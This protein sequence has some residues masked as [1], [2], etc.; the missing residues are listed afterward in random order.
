MT[1]TDLVATEVRPDGA[2]WYVVQ[3]KPRS[4]ALAQEHL[5]RQ[6]FETY[7][8]GFTRAGQRW[9]AV[10]PRYMFARPSEATQSI[11]PM[12][13]TIGVSHLVRFGATPA[14]IGSEV[15]VE[16]EALVHELAGVPVSVSQGLV[17]G[18]TV[19]FK[20]GALKGLEGLIKA[21]ANERVLILMS[22]L[23]REVEV[24]V[25]ATQVELAR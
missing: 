4:E 1:M 9:Q 14:T 7:L 6:G 15:L 11:A 3:T 20:T 10:F 5:R 19:R 13:S 16:I 23:G 2:R 25:E 24:Q 21:N 12:R 18:A 8:P 22:L 17:Q